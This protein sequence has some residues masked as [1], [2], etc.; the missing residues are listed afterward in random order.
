MV[1]VLDLFNDAGDYSQV[2]LDAEEC[3]LDATCVSPVMESLLF[4]L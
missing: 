1:E 2:L 3:V 4:L